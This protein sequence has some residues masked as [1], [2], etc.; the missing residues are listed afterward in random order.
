M[1]AA[2][3]MLIGLSPV[4]DVRQVAREAPR[5]DEQCIDPD[6]VA[7]A[8]VTRCEVLGRSC[9]TAQSIFVQRP[10]R[11]LVS[12]T[13]LDLDEGQNP[14]ASGNQIYFSARDACAPRKDVP[15]FEAQPPCRDCLRLASARLGLLPVQSPPPSS[16]ART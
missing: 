12:R 10:A 4:P 14:T 16:S 5:H 7:L 15:A 3:S 2:Y 11:C 13:L 6:V 8:S 9:D 1:R